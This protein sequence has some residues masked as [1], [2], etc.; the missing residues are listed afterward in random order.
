MINLIEQEL[1]LTFREALEYGAKLVN[2]LPD[3]KIID[4][5]KNKCKYEKNNY[6]N[7]S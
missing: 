2:Y 5:V 4:S 3:A 6:R 1:G 7:L